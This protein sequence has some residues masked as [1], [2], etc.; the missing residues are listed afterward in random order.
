[1]YICLI[2]LALGQLVVDA[3]LLGVAV[4]QDAFA[5]LLAAEE[6]EDEAGHHVGG[7]L[8]SGILFNYH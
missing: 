4:R 5:G 7:K 6:E 2:T 8:R 3:V 1:M